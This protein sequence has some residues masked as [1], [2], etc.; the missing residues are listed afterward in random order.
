MIRIIILLA[1]ITSSCKSETRFND[2]Y[3]AISKDSP[4]KVLLELNR[5][6]HNVYAHLK[7]SNISENPVSVDKYAL[8]T[9]GK[10]E[11]SAFLVFCGESKLHYN[12]RIVDRGIP[13]S[14]EYITI[15]PGDSLKSIVELSQYYSVANC[16]SEIFARFNDGSPFLSDQKRSESGSRT[17]I[18]VSNVATI[19]VHDK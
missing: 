18:L 3:S 7:F 1:F 19:K 16:E 12:G 9:S 15:K 10:L 11:G 14:S 2:I 8:T 6:D 13:L 5:N 17:T 4:I